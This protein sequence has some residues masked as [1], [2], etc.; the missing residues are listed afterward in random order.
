MLAGLPPYVGL[1]ASIPPLVGYALF[2]SSRALAVGPGRRGL[3]DDRR[4]GWQ[5]RDAR[6][7]P[8]TSRRRSLLAALSGPFLMALGRARAG[9]SRQP[10]EPPGDLGLH[11]G[12]GHPDRR[13]PAQ[14]HPGDTGWRR[15]ADRDPGARSPCTRT[16]PTRRRMAVGALAISFLFWVRSAAEAAAAGLGLHRRL[17]DIATKAGP[18]AAVAGDDRWRCPGSASRVTVARGRHPAGLPPLTLPPLDAALWFAALAGRGPD[19]PGRLRRVGLGRADARGEE[20]PADRPRPGAGGLGAA[21]VAG[22][23]LR[24]LSGH[25]RLRP[26]G[27]ELRRRR[28]DADGRRVH[29]CGHRAHRRL[30]DAAVLQP[31]DRRRWPPPSS[32]PCCPWST[33]ARCRRTWAYSKSDFIA[34]AATI[35]VVLG[36]GVEAGI[37]AGVAVSILLCPVADQPAAHGDRR[38]GA[39][40]RALPQRA[41]SR[42]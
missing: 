11:H 9:L 7:R 18:I 35:L 39:G 15:H 13:E 17:A 36:V 5:D 28:R 30:P 24:R 23:L 37:V 41:P 26:L 14:A 38:P 20:A 33:S 22:R 31:A 34:M 12:L 4:C 25:R 8:S 1:Y 40:H 6:Q 42:A 16:A 21:N 10:L 27:R 2:G 3:A 19:Q 29:R 32:S